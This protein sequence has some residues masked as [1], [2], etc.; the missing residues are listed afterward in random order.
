MP[1]DW[2]AMQR[3]QVGTSVQDY[4]FADHTPT[5]GLGGANSSGVL[6]R[7]SGRAPLDEESR[8][9]YHGRQQAAAH[10]SGK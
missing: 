1:P 5:P 7:Y 3:P 4:R 9:Q 8:A 2:F 6:Y 10:Q